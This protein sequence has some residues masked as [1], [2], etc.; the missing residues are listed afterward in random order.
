MSIK[1][2]EGTHQIEITGQRQFVKNGKSALWLHFHPTSVY[3]RDNKEWIGLPNDVDDAST[4]LWLS[5]K[6]SG[7]KFMLDQLAAI[8]YT[9]PVSDLLEDWNDNGVQYSLVGVMG[10]AVNKHKPSFNDPEKVYDNWTFTD[11]TEPFKAEADAD[12]TAKGLMLLE[13]A[14][15]E[16]NGAAV[17]A[18]LAKVSE[19]SGASIIGVVEGGDVF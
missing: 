13:A 4:M 16:R 10:M 1:H 19:A 8:G 6:E 14:R 11:T 15:R 18:G 9:G 7:V 12:A 3:N 2:D 17:S 5:P